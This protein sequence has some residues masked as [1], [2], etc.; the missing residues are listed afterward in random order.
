[1]MPNLEQVLSTM[2]IMAEAEYAVEVMYRRC[3]AKWKEDEAFWLRLAAQ[4][5]KHARNIERMS[6]ILSHKPD[7]F[8]T[9][10]S[11]HPAAVETFR[12]YIRSNI[13][14]VKAQDV[15]KLNML[16]IARDIENSL[17]EADAKSRAFLIDRSA[18]WL[19]SVDR[20]VE[21]ILGHAELLGSIDPEGRVSAA[22]I[23]Q[24][25]QAARLS[26][27][28]LAH[29]FR[30]EMGIAPMQYL[31]QIRIQRAQE[32]LLVTGNPI[33]QV[34]REVGFRDPFYF[35]RIFRKHC[36]VGPRAFRKGATQRT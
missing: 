7:L 19:E 33:A 6:A 16:Y 17:L 34:A 36:E 23:T 11:V 29:L 4:E 10:R 28:R 20:S 13:E 15:S 18:D 1:M 35:N 27:S 21:K 14:K 9:R 25:A 8:Q 12:D 22:R 5:E 31:E 24:L 26:P 3:A 2:K 30:Q 32:L